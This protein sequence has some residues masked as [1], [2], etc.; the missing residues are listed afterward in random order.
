MGACFSSGSI[1]FLVFLILVAPALLA[2]DPTSYFSA[3]AALTDPAR[4]ATLTGERAANTRLHKILACL[5]EARRAGII[6]SK[7]ID[8]A[9][10]LTGDSPIHSA[11]VKETLLWNFELCQRGAVFTPDNL[12]RMKQGRAP[13]VVGGSYG[14]QPY[15]VDHIIPIAEHPA[16]GRE[17]ANLIYLPRTVNRRKSDDIRQRT[18]DLAQKLT[19]AGILTPK[20][21][22]RLRA[23]RHHGSDATPRK[24]NLNQSAASTLERLPGIGPQTAAA[25]IAARPIK[26]LEALEQV[27]GLG[28]KTIEALREL[29]SF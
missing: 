25:I 28:P 1:P 20:D 29:V 24:V 12:A 26:D 10:R 17:L 4:L 21:Y 14:G 7:A 16:L 27:P 13:L 11:A 18:L 2:A 15:E 3:I 8:E 5:E 9:H 23:T 19:A 22:A 6:P